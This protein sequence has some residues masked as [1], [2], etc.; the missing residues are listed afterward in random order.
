MRFRRIWPRG[1]IKTLQM[2]P[3]ELGRTIKK[4]R[5]K[6]GVDRDALAEASNVGIRFL[7]ELEAGKPTAQVGMMF[8]VLGALG[9]RVT[10]V[11]VG[12]EKTLVRKSARRLAE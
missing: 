12:S 10:L 3:K 4:A 9:L 6:H 1:L 8:S 11:E 2:T 5:R 7:T